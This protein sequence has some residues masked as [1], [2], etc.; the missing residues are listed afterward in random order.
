M[1][2]STVGLEAMLLGKPVI[3]FGRLTLHDIYS[4]GTVL[5][6]K[7]AETLKKTV[8]LAADEKKRER[9][10]KNAKKLLFETNYRQDG[11]SCQRIISL[12]KS[13]IKK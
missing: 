5:K 2:N 7:D 6:A 8:E 10:A 4:N 11:K 9:L 1:Q 12:I 13:S 3:K